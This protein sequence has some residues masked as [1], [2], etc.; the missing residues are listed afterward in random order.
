M[1]MNPRARRGRSDA[2]RISPG[3]RPAPTGDPRRRQPARPRP[4][5][6]RPAGPQAPAASGVGAGAVAESALEAVLDDFTASWERGEGPKA[7]RYLDRIRFEDSAELIY[8]EYCLAEASELAP[9][10]AD[11][12]RRFPHHADRLSRLFSLHGAFSGSTLRGWVEPTDLPEAGDEIGPYRLLREL[13][14]GAFARVFL[15]EQ[16]DLDR[17]LVV[18][19]VSTRSTAEPRLLARARHPHIV[20]VLRHATTDDGSLHL[21]CMPFLGGATLAAV[22]E[23]R[24]ELG[25]PARSGADLLADLDRASAPEYPSAELLRPAREVIAGLTHPKALAW[26]VARL[27]EALDHAHGRGVAHGD[28][29]PSNILLTAEATP[30][31]LDMNLSTDWRGP[32]EG[33]VTDGQGAD[34]GGTPAYMA[35]ERLLAIARGGAASNASDS[36]RSDLYALGLVLL[37]ALTG[38]GPE[39]PRSRPKDSRD[40]ARALAGLRQDLPGP[41][42]G[43][44]RRSIPPA[45]R[46]ILTKCLCPDPA[47]RHTRG[48]ELAEDLDLWRSDLPLAFAREPRRSALARLARRRR[49]PLIATGL[50]LAAALMVASVASVLMKGSRRDEARAKY[51]GQ[52]VARAD[53]GAFVYRRAGQWRDD[54]LSDPAEASARQLA[55]YDVQADTDWRRRDDV[56]SLPDD[57][58]EELEAWLLEQVLRHAVALRLRPDSPDSWRRAL[59]LLVRT[60]AHSPSTALRAERSTLLGLLG[61]PDVGP[62][63]SAGASPPRWMDAYLAGVAAEPLHARESLDHYREALRDRPG[64]FWAHYRAATVAFRVGEYQLA[65]E[66]LR[67]CTARSPENPALHLHLASALCYLE[68][69]TPGFQETALVTEA[70]V[71][72]DRA[73]ELDPDYAMAY[74]IRASVRQASGRADD[75]KADLSR[76]A[77][78][79]T[80]GGPGSVLDLGLSLNF[81]P[82]PDHADRSPLLHAD[83]RKALAHEPRNLAARTTLAAMLLHSQPDEALAEFDRVLEADPGHLRARYQ[84]ANLLHQLESRKGLAEFAILIEDPRFQELLVEEPQAFRAFHYLATD[85]LKRGQIPESLALARRSLDLINTTRTLGDARTHSSRNPGVQISYSPKGETH[86]LLARIHAAQAKAEAGG[87]DLVA[88]NLG[89]CFAIDSDFRD[90]WFARDP[91]FDGLRD[92]LARRLQVGP[93]DR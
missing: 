29:K 2:Q 85:L 75:A 63:P 22:L 5:P 88:D 41:L 49:F 62:G 64:L 92:E 21:V 44:G 38:V 8:H 83:A 51:R 50:T 70:L 17:R 48:N 71:E 15:A 86:Y 65:A 52:V 13:G 12:L 33:A 76:L 34:L 93:V 78:L 55:R 80:R 1:A 59:D 23:A 68:A 4:R 32:D 82:G 58:R 79:T 27:A 20:E 73:V 19:K 69:E 26:V 35:P 47:G 90:R 24:R 66:Q 16:S 72:C 84:R 9:D 42:R 10:A 28:L 40:L 18:L 57:E 53:S 77:A 56:R 39:V 46:S 45:L 3:S 25:R 60:L 31:L 11:Y 43:R 74:H 7:E 89:R 6:D 67:R 91:R 61:M 37:E 30:L 54:D 87:V 36:H 81:R 14:R